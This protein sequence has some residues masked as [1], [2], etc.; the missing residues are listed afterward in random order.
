MQTIVDPLEHA[1]LMATISAEPL[2][3]V[4][5]GKVLKLQLRAPFWIDHETRIGN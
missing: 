4:G 5:A 2:A 3:E 1:R